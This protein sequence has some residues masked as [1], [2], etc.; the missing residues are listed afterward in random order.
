M[1]KLFG[2]SMVALAF[3]VVPSAHA[4]DGLYVSGSVGMNIPNDSDLTDSAIP[5]FTVTAEADNGW[6]FGMAVGYALQNFRVEAEFSYLTNDIDTV[7]AYGYSFDST[8]DVSA[9][10]GL[11]NG[12]F[13]IPV[14]AKFKPFV[15]AGLGLAKVEINDFNIE[16]SGVADWSDDDVV[17]AWQVGAGMGYAVTDKVILEAKYRYFQTS[18][19]EF[20]DG[21]NMEYSGH[22]ILLGVRYHF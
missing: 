11:I 10:T 13:D 14:N 12:Y 1:K 17:F 20:E 21:T 15:T 9:A 5:G 18:D 7:K 16:G 2:V 6:A 19:P 22:V 4:G 3:A 8:G